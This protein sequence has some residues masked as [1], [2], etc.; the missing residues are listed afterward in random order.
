MESH[1]THRTCL[2]RH[3]KFNSIYVF[4]SCKLCSCHNA[5]KCSAL[6][7]FDPVS[8]HIFPDVYAS[9]KWEGN[10][11]RRGRAFAS[12]S[13]RRQG[14]HTTKRNAGHPRWR[15]W[16]QH[17][18]HDVISGWLTTA[19]RPPGPCV[20]A[21]PIEGVLIAVGWSIN[22]HRVTAHACALGCCLMA[23]G[24]WVLPHGCLGGGCP[25]PMA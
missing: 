18:L 9:V 24:L 21:L 5:Q 25:L 8:Q 17:L 23:A 16:W 14:C 1:P 22:Q 19:G 3:S 20:S 12:R 11:S 10:N 15:W 13:P 7:V 6:K 4:L 2:L